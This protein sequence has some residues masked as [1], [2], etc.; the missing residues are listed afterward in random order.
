MSVT[1]SIFPSVGQG[2]GSPITS[3]KKFKEVLTIDD[4]E[5]ES[6]RK[7]WIEWEKQEKK[8]INGENVYHLKKG[9]FYYVIDEYNSSEELN[10]NKFIDYLFPES[11]CN[12]EFDE[13]GRDIVNGDTTSISFFNEILFVKTEDLVRVV[14]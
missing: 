13:T 12:R 2:Y 6:E 9:S 7:E 10:D 5:T 1:K 8:M 4:C 3:M 14:G 11:I